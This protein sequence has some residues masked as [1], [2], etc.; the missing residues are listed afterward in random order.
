MPESGDSSARSAGESSQVPHSTARG[1]PLLHS[2]GPCKAKNSSACPYEPGSASSESR[3]SE[4]I[5]TDS[6]GVPGPIPDG[7]GSSAPAARYSNSSVPSRNKRHARCRHA[8]K[9]R[10]NMNRPERA[11]ASRKK[12]EKQPIVSRKISSGMHIIRYFSRVRQAAAKYSAKICMPSGSRPE[13]WASKCFQA[14]NAVSGAV[15]AIHCA[16]QASSSAGTAV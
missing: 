11:L 16:A 6:T 3:A 8:Q 15:S 5:C 7:R 1:M 13:N 9:A 14:G 2:A 4:G 10:S 12:R